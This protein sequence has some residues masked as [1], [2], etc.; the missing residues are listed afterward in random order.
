MTNDLPAYRRWRDEF[1]AALDPRLYSIDWLDDE[2][3]IGTLKLFACE[4]AAVLTEFRHYPTGAFDLHFMLG[5]GSLEG[6]RDML[7]PQVEAWA[8]KEG[9][10]GAIVE[11]RAGWQRALMACGYEPH[12]VSLRKDLV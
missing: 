10:L 11:S 6:L 12:Q 5:A 2:V 9:A 8:K 7:R 1:A 4:D 3:L